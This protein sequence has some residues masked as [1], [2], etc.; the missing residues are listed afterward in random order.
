MSAPS[1]AT[2][3]A[4]AQRPACCADRY[5]LG[6]IDCGLLPEEDKHLTQSKMRL[7]HEHAT[8]DINE[9][10]FTAAESTMVHSLGRGSGRNLVHSSTPV[11]LSCGRG[12]TLLCAEGTGD[13]II[14]FRNTTAKGHVYKN[15]YLRVTGGHSGFE[16]IALIHALV[17][18]IQKAQA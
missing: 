5:E 13:L 6:D 15:G 9:V 11:E 12:A 8:L 18:I 2:G 4:A 17:A 14:T 1:T 10:L 16:A 7:C 3:E